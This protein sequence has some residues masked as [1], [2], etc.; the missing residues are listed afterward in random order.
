V[1]III[2]I[3]II[4][5][6]YCKLSRPRH[7]STRESRQ[8]LRAGADN[9]HTA[10]IRVRMLLSPVAA[11]PRQ[12]QCV[13]ARR[14]LFP[15]KKRRAANPR[16]PFPIPPNLFFSWQRR[17][18]N[19]DNTAPLDCRDFRAE[20]ANSRTGYFKTLTAAY[21]FP[22]TILRLDK[23]IFEFWLFFSGEAT[24][25]LRKTSDS[26]SPLRLADRSGGFEGWQ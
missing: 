12:S 4:I 21:S 16:Y 7:G 22:A 15:A 5:I 26:C 19:G 1:T 14:N 24:V 13:P 20:H 9:L 18:N 2:I 10:L 11:R 23:N 25:S 8:R 17:S 3:I 6:R